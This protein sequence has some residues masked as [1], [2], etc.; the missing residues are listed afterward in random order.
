MKSYHARR[1]L[2]FLPV[3]IGVLMILFALLAGG[4]VSRSLVP[5]LDGTW[6][7][8]TAPLKTPT[9]MALQYL[10]F[11]AGAVATLYTAYRIA[12]LAGGAAIRRDLIPQLL[13]IALLV[14]IN[15][16]VLAQP[17]GQ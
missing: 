17:T 5:W 4:A 10:M 12:R 15:V 11:G 14:A 1:A 2:E 13:L 8:G 9:I 3:A 16:H 7:G 6:D